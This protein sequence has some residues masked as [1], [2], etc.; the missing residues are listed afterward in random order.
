MNDLVERD[1]DHRGKEK[2][3]GAMSLRKQEGKKATAPVEVC[4]IEELKHIHE[5]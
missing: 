3:C 1:V 2:S 5:Q 4:L